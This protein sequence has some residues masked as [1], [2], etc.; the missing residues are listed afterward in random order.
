VRF[1]PHRTR[2]RRIYTAPVCDHGPK[3]IRWKR[4]GAPPPPKNHSEPETRGF[5]LLGFS[6]I[7]SLAARHRAVAV[8]PDNASWPLASSPKT[9]ERMRVWRRRSRLRSRLGRRRRPNNHRLG[10]PTASGIVPRPYHR[11]SR[12][13]GKQA[14]RATLSPRRSAIR[15]VVVCPSTSTTVEHRQAATKTADR[16]PSCHAGRSAPHIGR[17]GRAA[18]PQSRG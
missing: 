14:N 9:G 15:P 11:A 17:E 6:R 13:R 4:T 10:S 2:Q 5:R 3:R 8:S 18:C 7:V 16:S 1:V 12:P